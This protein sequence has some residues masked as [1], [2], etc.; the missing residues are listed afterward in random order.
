VNSKSCSFNLHIRVVTVWMEFT[1]ELRYER[2]SS[3]GVQQTKTGRTKFTL[4]V[5]EKA[6]VAK[7]KND[8]ERRPRR[9]G[10]FCT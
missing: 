1:A 7:I 3:S 4:D 2:I 9:C 8:P 10:F 6:L 5:E